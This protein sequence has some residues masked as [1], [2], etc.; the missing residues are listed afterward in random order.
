[1]YFYFSPIRITINNKKML[2]TSRLEVLMAKNSFGKILAGVAVIGAG[3]ALGLAVYNKFDT[4]K[5]ELNDDEFED[6]FYDDDFDDMDD[7]DNYVSITPISEENTIEDASDDDSD[8][9]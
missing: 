2:K 6:D 9:E 1:M 7:E 5:K 4:I 3:V 8:T